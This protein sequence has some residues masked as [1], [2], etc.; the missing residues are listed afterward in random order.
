MRLGDYAVTIPQGRELD[1]GYVE[2][3]HN[4]TYTIA[5]SNYGK[6]Q[7][8]AAVE[9]DGKL[10][11]TWRLP[12]VSDDERERWWQK[13]LGPKNQTITI[14]RPAHDTGKFTFYKLDSPEAQKAGLVRDD[15][16][17][18]ISVLFKPGVPYESF[19]CY[20][21][22]TFSR[23]SELSPGGTG[24]SGRSQQKFQ[25]V[26]PLY[27]DEKAFVLIHL[28]LGWC[29]RYDEPRP[30]TALTSPIPPSLLKN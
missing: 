15:K 28:R 18:L 16:L 2:I 19:V 29:A 9:I 1:S 23:S 7:C 5:L 25:T 26:E 20:D 22:P 8:D 12:G 21:R 3:R 27:Y 10:V 24:L 11:G 4:T 30:L 13:F 14:E 6:L 17:G